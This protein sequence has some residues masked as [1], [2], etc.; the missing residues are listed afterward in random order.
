MKYLRSLARFPSFLTPSFRASLVYLT[1]SFFHTS[2][3]GDVEKLVLPE[4]MQYL[5][6]EYCK[7]LTGKLPAS[8]K[9]KC[10]LARS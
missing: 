8:E 2:A 4:G 9:A 10:K 1:P 3:A 7:G 5:D 6:I